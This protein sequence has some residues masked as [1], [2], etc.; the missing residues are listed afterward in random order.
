LLARS[1]AAHQVNLVATA[2]PAQ[3]MILGERLPVPHLVYGQSPGAFAQ[4]TDVFQGRKDRLPYEP[5]AVL[6]PFE[7]FQ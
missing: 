4:R 2:A 1:L 7:C 5:G 3:R 6:Y